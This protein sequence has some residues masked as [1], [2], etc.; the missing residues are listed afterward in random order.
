MRA[1]SK[2]RKP[3]EASK[4]WLMRDVIHGN[5]CG[6]ALLHYCMASALSGKP[7]TEIKFESKGYVVGEKEDK[8]GHCDIERNSG[9]AT[10]RGIRASQIDVS[11]YSAMTCGMDHLVHKL[12]GQPAWA[13]LCRSS[14]VVRSRSSIQSF[15]GSSTPA[16]SAGLWPLR[17]LPRPNGVML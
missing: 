2:E 11:G 4:P 1:L 3:E 6:S 16:N 10:S 12:L 15:V 17:T 5:S 8:Y 14:S 7:A 13:A 9:I